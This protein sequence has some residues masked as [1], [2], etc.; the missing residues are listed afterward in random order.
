LSE[1]GLGWGGSPSPSPR[2]LVGGV[3]A[4]N[5]ER[6]LRASVRSLTEQ[7]LPD[8]VRWGEIWVVASGCT[9]STVEVARSLAEEDPRVRLVIETERG[10]K[11]RA[12]REVFQR[13]RGDALVL[14]NSDARAEPGAVGE[15]LRTAV[16][17]APPFAVMG[18]PIVP[19]PATGRWAPTFRWM[20]QLHHEFHAELL[21]AGA[22]GHLSDELLLVSLPGVP[23][24]PDGIIND[25][26]YLAVWLAQ[27]SGGRWYAS[28]ARVSIEVPDSVR[29][30][31]HQRRRIHVGNAQVTSVLREPPATIPRRF[32]EQPTQTARLLRRMVANDGGFVHFARLA[33]WEFASHALAVWDRMPPRKDHVRW[34]RIRSAEP[35]D[36]LGQP[37]KFPETARPEVD[38]PARVEERVAAV[39]EV[40]S[41]FRTG[42]RLPELLSLLPKDAPATVPEVRNWLEARPD[43]AHVEG[44]VAFA[45]ET[46]KAGEPGRA[47]RGR[48][49]LESARSLLAGPLRGALN[50]CQCVCVTGSAAYGL[51]EHGDDLDLFVVTQ[52]GGLWW[53]LAYTYLSIRLARRRDAGSSGPVPCFNFVLESDEAVNEFS[54]KQGFLFARE[55]LTALPMHGQ[56]FYRGL[57]ARGSWMEEEIPRLYAEKTPSPIASR[58]APASAPLIVRLLNGAV[59]PW[60][61]AYLQLAGL[62]RDGRFR[63]ASM[64]DHQFRTETRWRRLAFASR[65]FERL[66]ESYRVAAPSGVAETSGDG[67]S[68]P[69]ELERHRRYAGPS[70]TS[71]GN[72]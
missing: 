67:P 57:L 63:R 62:R 6:H 64:S 55:A 53:F 69:P 52:R 45:P 19:D 48:H 1:G 12:L 28:G 21:S 36:T 41:Q 3:V 66:R 9:D 68:S 34:R 33:A 32:L 26:S 70:V 56:E 47:E 59:F 46:A 30:H 60:L 7:N 71:T 8:G 37:P 14:L 15:L 44:E 39:V 10:G 54:R 18:R 35:T 49:Y 42:V 58:S 43:L 22:G 29:D 50:W 11:A 27:H 20:W 25:G 61:A 72:N 2:N 65:K 4:H 40:A 5:E 23:P 38:I 17:K 24:I 16:G 51:P 31:L 13:A